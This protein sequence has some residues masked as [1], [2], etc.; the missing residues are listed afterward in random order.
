[1]WRAGRARAQVDAEGTGLVSLQHFKDALQA[2]GL[3]GAEAEAIFQ[4]IDTNHHGQITYNEFLASAMDITC[5]SEET[6]R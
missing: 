4:S 5:V 3:Q 6:I 1:V 2:S